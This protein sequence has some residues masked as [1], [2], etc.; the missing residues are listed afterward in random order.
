MNGSSVFKHNN[1]LIHCIKLFC[2]LN[3]YLKKKVLSSASPASATTSP[4]L[5]CLRHS[6]FVKHLLEIIMVINRMDVC[7]CECVILRN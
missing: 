4:S 7:D 5:F 6:L 3:R 1:G 2:G